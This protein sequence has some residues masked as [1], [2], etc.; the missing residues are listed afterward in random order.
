MLLNGHTSGEWKQ[1][2]FALQEEMHKSSFVFQESVGN[3]DPL[4]RTIWNA[5]TMCVKKKAAQRQETNNKQN[6]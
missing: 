1:G 6:Q 3:Y 4:N 2:A 5:P